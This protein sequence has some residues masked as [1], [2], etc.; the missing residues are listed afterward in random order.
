LS[1]WRDRGRKIYDGNYPLLLPSEKK[2]HKWKDIEMK[3]SSVLSLTSFAILIFYR[4][5]FHIFLKEKCWAVRIFLAAI[6]S[7][8]WVTKVKSLKW[9][10]SITQHSFWSK[11]SVPSGWRT[12]TFK[13]IILFGLGRN[14]NVFPSD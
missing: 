12:K 9:F 10:Q 7:Y 3:N 4:Q 13:L 5:T 8:S 1:K 11:R 6:H 2:L 14:K